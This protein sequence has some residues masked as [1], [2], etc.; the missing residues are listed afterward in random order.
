MFENYKIQEMEKLR[1][2]R[3]EAVRDIKRDK[4]LWE[5]QRKAA[6]VLPSK[7]ERHEMEVLRKQIESLQ[8][9]AREEKSRLTLAHDRLKRRVED[10]T[11]RNNELQE[12]VKVLEQQRATWLQRNSTP[13]DIV[14]KPTV[15]KQQQPIVVKHPRPPTA[16]PNALIPNKSD[17]PVVANASP[18]A[19]KKRLSSKPSQDFDEEV[20]F[21]KSTSAS[22]SSALRK[23]KAALMNTKIACPELDHM[24][25]KLGLVGCIEQHDFS[26]GKQIR[27]YQHGVKLVRYQNRTIKEVHPKENVTVIHF[28]NGDYKKVMSDG[29]IVYWYSEP[30]TLHTTFKDG[31]QLYEF[32]SGQIEKHYPDG[33]NEIVFADKTVKY[34]YKNGEEESLFPDGRIQR[35]DKQGKKTLEH[36]SGTREIF[37]GGYR[38]KH[39]ADGT[40]RE[41]KP[42]GTQETR[43]IDGRVRIKDSQGHVLYDSRTSA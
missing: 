7:K 1:I 18:P 24:Q 36:P 42:D 9:S 22:G 25:E 35:V 17:G 2:M 8:N 23:T 20:P 21:T 27:I 40:I 30:R 12:E 26:D 15:T 31:L 14:Q 29:R 39:F 41:V 19:S 38:T 37:H 16:L 10:L 32:S 28:T 6:D 13:A 34:I 5:R 3:E 43:W 33:T 4:S 11:K